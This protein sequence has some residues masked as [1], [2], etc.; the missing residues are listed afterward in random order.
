LDSPDELQGIWKNSSN[1][2]ERSISF[3]KSTIEF[4][5]ENA[6]FM[7]AFCGW[8]ASVQEG[9]SLLKAGI[10]PPLTDVMVTLEGCRTLKDEFFGRE[11]TAQL[12]MENLNICQPQQFVETYTQMVEWLKAWINKASIDQLEKFLHCVTGYKSLNM[13]KI[14][15]EQNY[16]PGELAQALEIHTCS[17]SLALPRVDNMDQ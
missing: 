2:S 5:G 3:V 17:N 6:S 15:I 1:S 11:I 16:R 14:L 10:G 7:H 13:G 4:E 9:L 12:V 8:K